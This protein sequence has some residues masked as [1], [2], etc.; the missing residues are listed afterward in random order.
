[1]ILKIKIR[2]RDFPSTK[3]LFSTTKKSVT[4]H[5]VLLQD[6][7]VQNEN[8]KYNTGGSCFDVHR[9]AIQV[10]SVFLVLLGHYRQVLG[11]C[12]KF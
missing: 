3:A 10:G 7:E 5:S 2:I 8:Y 12:V 4:V 1:M 11:F 6:P 9:F